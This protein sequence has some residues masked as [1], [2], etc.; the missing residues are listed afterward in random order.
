MVP[1]TCYAVSGTEI[2]RGWYQVMELA[3]SG[4]VGV[5]DIGVVTPYNAHAA[6]LR[7]ALRL[8]DAGRSLCTLL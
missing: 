6:Y 4:G 7:E 3:G 1:R 2:G 5:G 8:A